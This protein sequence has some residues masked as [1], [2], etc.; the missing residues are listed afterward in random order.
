MKK[1][2]YV[3]IIF[4]VISCTSNHKEK[5]TKVSYSK[6]IKIDS[7]YI[8][9]VM[10]PNIST[11]FSGT[12]EIFDN[13]INF[14][15][16]RFGW[17]YEFN[18]NGKLVN[19]HLGQGAGPNEINTAYLDGYVN[20]KSGN[21]LFL[22]S[23]F[24]VHVHSDSSFERIKSYTFSWEGAQDVNKVRTSSSPDVNQF[25]LY[26]LDYQNLIIRED[27]N[28]NVYLPIYG[29]TQYFNGINSDFYYDKG[30][31]LARLN[32]KSGRIDKLLG[33]RSPQYLEQKYLPHHSFFSYDIDENN[34]FYVS[35]EIDS[36]IFKYDQNFDLVS[37][38]GSKGRNMATDYITMKQFDSKLF[39]DLYFN[40]RPQLGWYSY[41]EFVDDV[42]LLFRSYTK[43]KHSDYDGLQIFEDETLIGDVQV[44][45]S[46][47]VKGYIEPYVYGELK[48]NDDSKL[49]LYR[50]KLENL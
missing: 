43:G 21:H 36:L 5:S 1:I 47:R 49:N 44:P 28:G 12:F 7:I 37:V 22:G 2:I 6:N 15:D 26:T 29:E 38:F 24:D 25:A 40:K 9:E 33:K 45:K 42:G 8:E 3:F 31:I 46:F 10:L 11:S 18:P 16:Q 50:F 39:K 14:V 34:Y 13:K 19:R 32:L 41:L 23:T 20:L 27:Q 30:H 35:H 17:V 48:T 4:T